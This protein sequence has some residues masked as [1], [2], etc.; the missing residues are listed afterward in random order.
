M[1]INSLYST[2]ALAETMAALPA[3]VDRQK[4][5]RRFVSFASKFCPFFVDAE[6]CP[7]SDETARMARQHH[8]GR[9]ISK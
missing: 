6:H 8:L 1:A 9:A 3:E 7:T 5:E 2:Q 4:I